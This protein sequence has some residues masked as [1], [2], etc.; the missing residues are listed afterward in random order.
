[1]KSRYLVVPFWLV[2]ALAFPFGAMAAMDLRVDGISIAGSPVAAGGHVQFTATVTNIGDQVTVAIVKVYLSSDAELTTFDDQMLWF[3]QSP[4]LS[5]GQSATVTQSVLIPAR[6]ATGEYFLGTI[7]EAWTADVNPADNVA[8]TSISVI[9]GSCTPD[10]FENDDTRANARPVGIDDLQ[11]RN[12][13]DDPNDWVSFQAIAGTRYGIQASRVGYNSDALSI[14]LFN[15]DGTL[16]TQTS[17]FDSSD[18]PKIIWTAPETAV[19]YVR[20][21]PAFGWDRVGPNTEYR[22]V[23]ADRLPDL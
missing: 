18:F 6:L 2:A 16:V 19:Y 12:H 10:A 9:G 4:V 17:A 15:A 14:A 7:T 22:F 1:M 3:A 8:V 11:M 5:P 23:I 21:R 20:V 13:C